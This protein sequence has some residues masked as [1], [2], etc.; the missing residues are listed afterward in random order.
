MYILRIYECS[1]VSILHGASIDVKGRWSTGGCWGP[2]MLEKQLK[3]D[4]EPTW[5]TVTILPTHTYAE[6]AWIGM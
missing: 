6:L 4:Q 5:L 1:C 2:Q 3:K